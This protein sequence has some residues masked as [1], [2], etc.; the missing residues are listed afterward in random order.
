MARKSKAEAHDESGI[1]TK[2]GSEMKIHPA[3]NVFPM[4]ESDQLASLAESIAKVGQIHP[5]LLWS[6][7]EGDMLIDGRN[8]FR[9]C[10]LAEIEPKYEHFE[11]D[12]DAVRNLILG[13]NLERRDLKKSQKIML[14]ATVFPEPQ[15]GGRGKQ[16][17]PEIL[18]RLK[19]FSKSKESLQVRLHQARQILPYADLVDSVL[20]GT[21]ELDKAY[22]LAKQ[23]RFAS[24]SEA[25]KMAMLRREAPEIA[26]LVPDT[27]TLSQAW[28]AYEQKLA[29]EAEILNVLVE[30]QHRT[31]TETAKNLWGLGTSQTTYENFPIALENETFLE[32]IDKFGA[33]GLVWE[34]VDDDAFRRGTERLIE[35]IHAIREK[36]NV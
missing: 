35:M 24:E 36:K 27:M 1:P 6:N 5:I 26:D 22:N 11:G 31:I 8:R 33:G 4:L 19:G 18:K 28:A 21:L 34:F 30:G 20:H 7:G 13:V 15:R 29:D 2:L 3:A 10:E 32:N 12:E 23:R 9:A 16:L 25:E 14:V 17:D